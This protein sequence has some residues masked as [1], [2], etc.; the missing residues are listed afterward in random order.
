MTEKER[1]IANALLNVLDRNDNHPQR[2]TFIV[3][4]NLPFKPNDDAMA[5]RFPNIIKFN[6]PDVNTAQ[7]VLKYHAQRLGFNIPEHDAAEFAQHAVTNKLS[8]SRIQ[9]AL[10][11]VAAKQKTG[12]DITKQTVFN[13]L[14]AARPQLLGNNH[15]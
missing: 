6:L 1:N 9:V 2:A 15:E 4:T 13:C 14:D 10:E 3:S 12:N 11:S 7:Q 5:R 8:H